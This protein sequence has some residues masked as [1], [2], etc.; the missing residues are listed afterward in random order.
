MRL[1]LLVLVLLAGCQAGGT[2]E[3]VIEINP[4]DHLPE[5]YPP[6]I[7]DVAGLLNGQAMAW[8]TYDYSIGAMDA[9]AQIRDNQGVVEF[10]L[11][12]AP[13]GEPRN[14][15][16]RL[17]L[18]GRMSGKLAAGPVAA[19]LVE[20]TGPVWDGP[21]QSSSGQSVEIVLDQVLDSKDGGYGHA[22]GHFSAVICAATGFPVQV[23]AT[24]CQPISGTF[25][26]DIQFD[27][28]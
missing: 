8:D 15:E 21:R 7:G 4:A 6:R 10:V 5:G 24:R 11:I 22:V 9:A 18:L 28:L 19:P 27:N 1:V 25:D 20:I 12:G 3:H 17:S 2:G 23:D 13:I 16:N 26:T 14:R